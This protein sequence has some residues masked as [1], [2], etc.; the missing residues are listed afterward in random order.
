MRLCIN[1]VY[2]KLRRL[3]EIELITLIN[4]NEN[5]F[6]FPRALSC[7]RNCYVGYCV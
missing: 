2:K 5:S 1:R 4:R 6:F 3:P 7:V